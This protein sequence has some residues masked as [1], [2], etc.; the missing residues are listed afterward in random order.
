MQE[1]SVRFFVGEE[2]NE[3]L[4]NKAGEGEKEM[5]EEWL[6]LQILEALGSLNEGAPPLC[7]GSCEMPSAAE[8][9]N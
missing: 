2:G 4:L 9:E 1:L 8:K 3:T 7:G 6:R 5:A